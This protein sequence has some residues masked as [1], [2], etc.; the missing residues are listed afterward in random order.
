MG[1]FVPSGPPPG[2][3]LVSTAP[4]IREVGWGGLV[5][6][7][8]RVGHRSLGR[9]SG[10]LLD[11]PGLQKRHCEGGATR[12]RP[13]SDLPL[14]C[15]A[16]PV[17]DCKTPGGE[18]RVPEAVPSHSPRCPR[19]PS[20][21]RAPADSARCGTPFCCPPP[22]SFAGA[23]RRWPWPP[24]RS[25]GDLQGV[26]DGDGRLEGGWGAPGRRVPAGPGPELW[27]EVTSGCTSPRDPLLCPLPQS[28]SGHIFPVE[29]YFIFS[30]RCLCVSS[31]FCSQVTYVPLSLKDLG[32][33]VFFPLH[34]NSG[35]AKCA[36]AR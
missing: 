12:S 24:G 20:S 14:G 6:R 10:L 31:S 8:G 30:S 21:R 18:S 36:R 5:E 34:L 23:A 11:R 9:L 35:L 32:S 22:T 27:L 19:F 4:G 33:L 3:E 25:V 2:S 28:G 1:L 16:R 29:S 26:G 17:P 15:E 13:S 7:G